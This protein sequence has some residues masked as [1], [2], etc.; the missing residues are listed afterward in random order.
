MAAGSADAE[1]A[2]D[3]V[4]LAAFGASVLIGGSNIVAVRLSNQDLPPFFGAGLRFAVAAAIFLGVVAAARIP[5]P[6]GRALIGTVLY[7]ILAF[8]AFYALGYWALVDLPA[9]VGA[10][11]LS[12]VPLLTFFFALAHR[13][14]PFRWRALIGA[15]IAISGIVIL[16]NGELT[17]ALPAT[18]LLAAFGAAICGAESG[19]VIKQFPPSHPVATNGLAMAIGAVLLVAISVISGEERALPD[20]ALVW[21][22][23]A[24]LVLLGS[25][26]LFALYLFVLKRWTAS[27]ASYQF[28]LIPIV[29]TLLGAWLVDEPITSAVVLGGAVIIVGV[30]VGALSQGRKVAAPAPRDKEVLAQRCSTT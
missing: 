7:G 15:L 2:P 13:L 28:V 26:A 29:A 24:Y 8:A 20:R 5:L 18:S 25:L 1:G 22:V 3:Q 10:V 6:R 4:T 19:V 12:S 23:L 17:L 16:I 30:Y 9:S 11:I 27:G 21:G 14:E